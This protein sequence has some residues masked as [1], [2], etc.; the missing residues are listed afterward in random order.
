M[1]EIEG[2]QKEGKKLSEKIWEM[3]MIFIEEPKNPRVN[4]L[5]VTHT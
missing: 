2:K 3:R 5:G 4:A 1:E